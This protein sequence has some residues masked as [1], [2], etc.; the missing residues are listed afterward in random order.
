MSYSSLY[1]HAQDFI[2]N[3]KN[4]SAEQD[5]IDAVVVEYLN[6]YSAYI[7]TDNIMHTDELRGGA[8]FC[9]G[10]HD[11]TAKHKSAMIY[12]K[13][14]LLSKCVSYCINEH[15]AYNNCKGKCDVSNDTAKC[16]IDMYISTY[17][18]EKVF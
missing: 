1:N 13:S 12:I 4:E 6:A 5:V 7:H 18:G 8:R 14:R 10:E 16:I 9:N 17:L 15:S 3:Y 11:I 2:I